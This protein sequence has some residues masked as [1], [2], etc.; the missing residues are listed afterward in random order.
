VDVA[1]LAAEELGR[2]L[3]E[4]PVRTYPALLSTEAD[5]L[6]W[7]RA[8]AQSGSV[9]VA[10]YQAS[11]RGRGGLP[12]Q[13]T[14]GE[15]L[16]FS[17]VLRPALSEA[18]EGWIYTVATAALADVIARSAGGEVTVEWPD[19]VRVAGARAAAVGVVTEVGV[20]GL[21]WAVV[22]ALVEGLAP[23]RGPA[24]TR[25]VEAVEDRLAQEP[26]RVLDDQRRRC[27]TLGRRV[28][29]L[30]IPMGPAGVRI[31][32]RA[33]DILADGALLIETGG[34]P[35]V[36]VLPHHLGFLEDPEDP[37]AGQI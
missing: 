20:A 16:G 23:P 10:D 19:E 5:A 4:R 21:T 34:G 3:P 13:V 33:V 6:A 17:L 9:V 30:L 12:W 2:L 1:D 36:A 32:G 29:A 35:R 37:T 31:E 15:G 24:L 25:F 22:T 14:Q 26:E 7:V 27:E 18:R 28:R 8:G 11:P